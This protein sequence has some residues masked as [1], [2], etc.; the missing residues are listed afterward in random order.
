MYDILLKDTWQFAKKDGTINPTKKNIYVDECHEIADPKN[1]QTLE[2]LSVK[3]S[4]QGRGF[5]IRLIT[6]TQNLP[7]F[8]SIPR[9]GQAI[10][11]NAYFKLFMRLGESDC[12]LLKNYIIFQIVK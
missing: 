5:G 6:A 11:D 7:D 9:Y 8:L 10:I 4:K 2:F 1:P 3:L 12:Q